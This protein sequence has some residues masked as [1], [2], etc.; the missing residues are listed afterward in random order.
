MKIFVESARFPR[1][2]G[3]SLYLKTLT[4]FFFYE[5]VHFFHIYSNIPYLILLISVFSR[6]SFPF[7]GVYNDGENICLCILPI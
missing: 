6:V 1:S 2:G 3:M 4:N 7:P 5:F